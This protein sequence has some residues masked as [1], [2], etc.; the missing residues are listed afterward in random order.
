M[1]SCLSTVYQL[2]AT[3][4]SGRGCSKVTVCTNQQFEFETERDH[5]EAVSRNRNPQPWGP[6]QAATTTCAQAATAILEVRGW[7]E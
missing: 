6:T 2:G 4:D 5:G 1:P 3:S 7:S